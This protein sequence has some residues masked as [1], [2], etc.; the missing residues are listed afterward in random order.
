MDPAPVRERSHGS[1]LGFGH[2]S[3]IGRLVASIGVLL[4]WAPSA[5]S[6][7]IFSEQQIL[8]PN[9][10]TIYYDYNN[11]EYGTTHIDDYWAKIDINYSPLEGWSLFRHVRIGC[12]R[13]DW[14]STPPG[15]YVETSGE[16][17]TDMDCVN[18]CNR[19]QTF[20]KFSPVISQC[21]CEMIHDRI[22]Y[23]EVDDDG[24]PF[25]AWEV[26]REYD[27]RSSMTPSCYD[28]PRRLVYQIVTLRLPNLEPTYRNYI[29]AVNALEAKPK[30][31]YDLRLERMV[32]N[33]VWD[34][35]KSRM[36]ALSFKEYG[37]PLDF[38]VITFNS[39][40]GVLM[41]RQEHFPL[42]S[43]ITS[44]GTLLNQGLASADGLSTV[45]ILWGTYY[46]VIPAA[47]PE[48]T[49]V[50]HT[51][52]AIDIEKRT[53]VGSITLPVTLMNLQ[54]NALDHVLYGA[55]SDIY[56]RYGYYRLCDAT[57]T[58][59]KVGQ[60]S[61]RKVTV[62]CEAT[63]LGDLPA[64]VNHMYLQSATIDHQY[65]Y[66]WF[67]YKQVPT[68]R[69]LILEYHHDDKDYN[70]WREE[71]LPLES[72]Y[73][74]LIQTAPR[75]IFSLYPPV[76]RYARFSSSGTKIYVAFNMPTLRGAIPI[77]S[78]GDEVPDYWRDEDEKTRVPCYDIFDD[79]TMK[80]IPS[81]MCQWQTDATL[82]I[83]LSPQAT[84]VPGD[85]VR[86][87]PG[88]IYAGRR[89][90]GGVSLFSQPST[91]FAVVQ[92]PEFIPIPEVRIAGNWY[93]DTCTELVLDATSSTGHGFRGTFY[94]SLNRTVNAT[95][96]PHV[97]QLEKIIYDLQPAGQ[98]P[99][100]I[101]IPPNILLG[102]HK[103]YF[104]LE[105]FSFWDP[106]I[107]TKIT[108]MVSVA[109]VPVPPL[110]IAGPQ[111][112][113][114][115][116]SNPTTLVSRLD[117]EAGCARASAPI[118]RYSWTG[119]LAENETEM[120]GG[121]LG[122]PGWDAAAFDGKLNEVTGIGSKSLYIKP[123]VMQPLT[124]YLF[125][126][127][128]EV[129]INPGTASEQTLRNQASVYVEAELGPLAARVAGGTNG[130][131]VSN[132]DPV[133]VD[134]TS[135]FDPSDPTGR[136]GRLEFN[137]TCHVQ[138]EDLDLGDPCIPG[139]INGS[140]PYV[141]C[142][143]ILSPL[144]GEETK[145]R[146]RG[147]FFN[148]AEGITQ[149]P[150]S[151]EQRYCMEETGILVIQEGFLAVGKYIVNM[152]IY[153][154]VAFEPENINRTS[155]KSIVVEV[156]EMSLRQPN[157]FIAAETEEP[158][159]ASESLRFVG[160]V[161]NEANE[162][163]YTW[164]WSI[165]Q[166]GL[167]PQYDIDMAITQEGYDV[168]QYTW[169]ELDQAAVDFNDP[170]DIRSPANSRY[171]ITVPNLLSPGVQYKI[172][173][174]ATDSV[175][176][177][178][179]QPDAS[180]W[181]EVRFNMVGGNPS[182]GRLVTSNLTGVEFET[183]FRFA[184]T[185]WGSEDLPLS[186]QFGYIQDPQ[187]PF[188]Q[189]SMLSA[190]FSS[191]RTKNTRLPAGVNLPDYRVQVLG[192][193]R[194][195]LGTTSKAAILVSVRPNPDLAAARERLFHNLFNLDPESAFVAGIMLAQTSQPNSPDLNRILTG[196][197]VQQQRIKDNPRVVP[198]TS[199]VTGMQSSI[200][201]ALSVKGNKNESILDDVNYLIDHGVDNDLVSVHGSDKEQGTDVM[202]SLLGTIDSMMPGEDAVPV[203]APIPFGGR[204]LGTPQRHRGSGRFLSKV[205]DTRTPTVQYQQFQQT[206]WL[207]RK[208]LNSVVPELLPGELPANY[209]LRG[210]DIYAGKD[211]AAVDDMVDPSL[212][213]T[214][215]DA[216]T[217]PN[218]DIVGGPKI[219]SYHYFEYKKFPYVFM[220]DKLPKNRQLK[221]TSS[222][223]A[224]PGTGAEQFIPN[225]GFR[226]NDPLWYSMSLEL[227]NNTG[228]NIDDAI[229]MSLENASFNLYPRLNAHHN[230]AFHTVDHA[231]TCYQ[232]QLGTNLTEAKYDA[233]GIVYSDQ[234][235]VTDKLS[236]FVVFVDDLAQELIF[237]T[238][239]SDDIERTYEDEYRTMA[240]VNCLV[241][242]LLIAL[243][244][245]AVAYY[246]DESQHGVAPIDLSKSRVV[247]LADPKEKLIGTVTFTFRRN[248]LLVAM[249]QRHRKLTRAKRVL[250]LLVAWLTIMTITTLFHTKLKFK[251]ESQFVA[252]GLVAG[253]LSFPLMQF[254]Q[255]L[256]EWRPETRIL[257]TPPPTSKP[258][259]PIPLKLQAQMPELNRPMRPPVP[260]RIVPPPPFA[261]PRV[262]S[263]AAKLPQLQRMQL[264]QLALPNLPP[265]LP[266]ELPVLQL[267]D[268]PMKI[269]PPPRIQRRTPRPPKEPPPRDYLTASGSFGT[270]PSSKTGPFGLS[271]PSLPA[272][273]AARLD[274]GKGAPPPPSKPIGMAPKPPKTPP[275]VSKMFFTVPGAAGPGALP[276]PPLAPLKA[277]GP[278]PPGAPGASGLPPPPT[279][280][281]HARSKAK[282][283]A[284]L[285]PLPKLM[286][287]ADALS[288][289]R[290]GS[291]SSRAPP[292]PPPPPPK[293]PPPGNLDFDALEPQPPE[294]PRSGDETF[295]VTTPLPGSL[296]EAETPPE[297]TPRS[298]RDSGRSPLD[299]SAAPLRQAAGSSGPMPGQPPSSPLRQAA[300]AS[301]PT[302]GQPPSSPLRQ[303]GASAS[304]GPVQ[305][306]S[307]P[308]R[309]AG[310]SSPMPGQ[311]PS[312]PLRRAG[313]SSSPQPGRLSPPRPAGTHSR[314]G[315]RSASPAARDTEA[316]A[317]RQAHLSEDP[318]H[319]MMRPGELPRGGELPRPPPMPPP[320]P[321][322]PRLN[323]D[324]A[325]NNALRV[326][327]TS[328]PPDGWFPKGRSSTPL[329]IS[330][331]PRLPQ[332]PSL[333]ERSLQQLPPPPP[334]RGGPPEMRF[335]GLGGRNRTALPPL[336]K[337]QLLPPSVA[338][339]VPS[340]IQSHKAGM[341]P[342]PPPPRL[343]EPLRPGE[344]PLPPED[345]DA[346]VIRKLTVFK[347]DKAGIR[348]P[349]PK[350]PPPKGKAVFKPTPPSGPPPAHA[351]ILARK[352]ANADIDEDALIKKAR[353]IDEIT[354]R[355]P[356]SEPPPGHT[357]TMPPE[358]P[359]RPQLKPVTPAGKEKEDL[360]KK[361][362]TA[363][364]VA[365][366]EPHPV[367]DWVVALSS[368]SVNLFMFGLVFECCLFI[369]V[370]GSYLEPSGVWATYGATLVGF[371][372]NL[373]LFESM[374]CVV[375]ACV[376]LIK[377]E[378]AKRQ[379]EI[380]ARRAR[381]ALK[382]QRLQDRSRRWK[383]DMSLPSLPPP[384]LLG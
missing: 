180:G 178:Q 369:V 25:D 42:Q 224:A 91:D 190:T 307:S 248:H 33:A 251:A 43:Q 117:Y 273:P 85:L 382:A 1:G 48:T 185:G 233:K 119:G 337:L 249:G 243:M 152:T 210:Q 383:Q 40:T 209:T 136:L 15:A 332:L 279:K 5:R 162:T 361:P 29:H 205:I 359:G 124:R 354:P 9:D 197:H 238:V 22:F 4:L 277:V 47:I 357:R 380:A 121:M 289:I 78:N 95:S 23:E 62:E 181:A 76:M 317:P 189:A 265:G 72:A 377:D 298:G 77:D 267:G 8:T 262:T 311:P 255:F 334:P 168:K 56:G 140:L 271:L 358:P 360:L 270:S 290:L 353:P 305:P 370:Y 236:D 283:P 371:I 254:V 17:L 346:T 65:N 373:G 11:T 203:A 295:I 292:P 342:P 259:T 206:R 87:R 30:F 141:A 109:G 49:Q 323:N 20:Y 330:G 67:V 120:L 338:L 368:W 74:S 164:K 34:F 46:T 331:P 211:F 234:S 192:W 53:V 135:S 297:S 242:P 44:V 231:A 183:M 253:V 129:I 14:D 122:I 52:V 194:S 41:V 246:V 137:W 81:S 59:I 182:G 230:Q 294:T 153:K 287:S 256:Y 250:S 113:Q 384:P 132:H 133:V 349:P 88:R 6:F 340:V 36:V 55:G 75:I 97:R 372:V 276:L 318:E 364:Q 365:S 99:Q 293:N 244:A 207:S 172:R 324:F 291:D 232:V 184:L 103:Y 70:L 320:G 105:V 220:D 333:G 304:P 90:P 285:P 225:Q 272:L 13:V 84:I 352:G 202:T 174:V 79:F 363:E 83:E 21:R 19:S 228:G 319:T 54:M 188:A 299:P 100:M 218:L 71:S 45:D 31:E 217:V 195:G 102:D 343:H 110:V 146:Y 131:S 335:L 187:D 281:G 134:G 111:V 223:F 51:I 275:P 216:F 116:V 32:F 266:L 112:I 221:M 278:P 326:A 118:V 93:L 321:A 150:L 86:I 27:Y 257:P 163:A 68:G 379:A 156:M 300:G 269:T 130:F 308:L 344:M 366:L 322:P 313:A 241:F 212:P 226:V 282:P 240:M 159:I 12:F 355:P 158:F 312:S 28:V 310:A 327:G 198:I 173:L 336:P 376:A 39:S 280:G 169:V 302:P 245:A 325:F 374:K 341:P 345:G 339:Q 58:T 123:Y 10:P 104:S 227:Y 252:T 208:I 24:C 18:F 138:E 239:T 193:T 7:E 315:S 147:D 261:P 314:N 328:T 347:G 213:L 149:P 143:P 160:Y 154:E 176:F 2:L 80:L 381:M 301:G 57:N 166:Y 16:E 107:S 196:Y 60:I 362:L 155:F 89:T 3:W 161:T 264:P 356:D 167:N 139:T 219:Y 26:F 92:I 268:R 108:K 61:R 165:S 263:E 204:R 222:N 215:Q 367:P 127:Q 145:F 63:K 288:F 329:A 94:W 50:V 177:A 258:A 66:A 114:V 191:E 157:V 101:R 351:Y 69:P 73:A 260:T 284:T 296:P 303:A 175:L 348:G 237:N 151:T 229:R 214:L 375:V 96:E 186:Y 37:A 115:K 98:T 201:N 316:P 171:L 286:R 144:T 128:A 199:E 274:T 235:C 142:Q 125:T 170:R 64:N 106:A 309:Q 179:G 148:H 35:G 126:V 38:T 350:P 306:P 200:L 378:T 82:F 247:D